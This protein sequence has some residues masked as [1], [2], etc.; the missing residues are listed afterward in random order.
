LV[1]SSNFGYGFREN[2]GLGA[3]SGL[4]KTYFLLKK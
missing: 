4:E 1:V 3:S 2:S